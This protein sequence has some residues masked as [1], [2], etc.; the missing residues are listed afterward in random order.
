MGASDEQSN[1]SFTDDFNPQS[2]HF[3]PGADAAIQRE[4]ATALF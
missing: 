1:L 3:G 2:S 4:L